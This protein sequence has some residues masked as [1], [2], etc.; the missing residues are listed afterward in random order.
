MTPQSTKKFT[1]LIFRNRAFEQDM[2]VMSQYTVTTKNTS[3]ADVE[4]HLVV[5]A[6]ACESLWDQLLLVRLVYSG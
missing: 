2:V 6:Q 4:T 5:S 1:L 3:R